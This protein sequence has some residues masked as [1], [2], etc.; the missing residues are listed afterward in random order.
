LNREKQLHIGSI[1]GVFGIK[2]WVK[3]FSFTAQREDILK[4]SP[5]LLKKNDAMRTVEVITGQLQNKGVVAQLKGVTD[6]ND[7]EE[8]VGWDI[9]IDYSKLPPL[10]PNEYYWL[11]LIG[12]EVENTDGVVLGFIESILE[13]GSNDVLIVQGNE[14]QHAIP[15]IQQQTVLMID[16][17]ANKM[18]VDWDADF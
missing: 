7:A 4:Y 9:F 15:F 2:G 17:A 1:S 3:I 12:M 11:D 6:R 10:K 16:L 5:W 13:T 14:R 8:L 18:H